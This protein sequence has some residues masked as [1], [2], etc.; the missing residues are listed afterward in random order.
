MMKSGN[1]RGEGDHRIIVNTGKSRM[2]I[3]AVLMPLI[4]GMALAQGPI[5]H[6]GIPG[7]GESVWQPEFYGVYA[8]SSSRDEAV[9]LAPT[10]VG[11]IQEAISEGVPTSQD[12]MTPMVT[13]A[14]DH[15]E[16]RY[17]PLMP[18][19]MRLVVFGPASPPQTWSITHASLVFDEWEEPGASPGHRL[20]SLGIRAPTIPL[21]PRIRP[22]HEN[23][24][25][26]ELSFRG[27]L[28]PGL[29]VIIPGNPREARVMAQGIHLV[30]IGEPSDLQSM[31]EQ[32]SQRRRAS[33]G[34]RQAVDVLDDMR[35]LSMAIEAYRLDWNHSP[36][37]VPAHHPNHMGPD[38]ALMIQRPGFSSSPGIG[39]SSP[40]AYITSLPLDPFS[41]TGRAPFA[42]MTF[43]RSGRTAASE[44][45]GNWLLASPGPDGDWDFDPNT[46][47][48]EAI[49]AALYN[50][51]TGE[52]DLLRSQR[53]DF[54]SEN[55][56]SRISQAQQMRQRL[57]TWRTAQEE[58]S[59][60][61]SG[62]T[63]VSRVRSDLRA[64][65]TALE[66]YFIDCSAYPMHIQGGQPG[67]VGGE[68]PHLAAVT[69]WRAR[70]G[71]DDQ[72]MMLTTPVAYI[73]S[74]M[75]DPFNPGMAEGMPSPF[76]YFT[77]GMG[78][79]I[80]SA[81]PDGDWDITSEN[82][83]QI[84]SSAIAQPSLT[85]ITGTNE[86]GEVL[87][88]DPTNGSRSSGDIYRVRQ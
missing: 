63:M 41:Q 8:L 17:I 24:D 49:E 23:T 12:A 77:D 56:E 35:T 34:P 47:T 39:I 78:W 4:A 51:L 3:V 82:V 68:N 45:I 11:Q 43:D 9:E 80:W 64:F 13:A 10:T 21:I 52:G 65:A 44:R 83:S 70:G 22:S 6:Q 25:L 84:Y 85:L 37:G 26:F 74:F 75:D 79:I 42:Y 7:P 5:R 76:A 2:G 54:F 38:D 53:A 66:S 30:A 59:V 31:T 33:L 27:P 32:I 57:S 1:H 69:T 18:D 58:I 88:F 48:D 72:F 20:Y 81:G 87:T 62:R 50:P 55:I 40:V 28:A 29:L 14:L 61:F 46:L 73:T 15:I 19:D 71:Y 67:A 86:R 36:L 60:Q 16:A